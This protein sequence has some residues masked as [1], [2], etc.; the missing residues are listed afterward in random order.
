MNTNEHHVH[1]A[2]CKT[3]GRIAPWAE[4]ITI[5]LVAVFFAVSFFTGRVKPFLAPRYVWLPGMA[6]VALLGMAAARL[7][8]HFRGGVTCCESE[9]HSAWR[10][11]R[12]ACVII[13]I[14]PMVLGV[15][16]A[17]TRYSS[18]GMRKRRVSGPAR[19]V[20]LE[21][22]VKWVMGGTA[23][24]KTG[25]G[26]ASL[27]ENP[28]VLDVLTAAGEGDA[29]ALEGTFVTVIGQ[30]DLPDGAR[31][32][33]FDI[34]RLVV[35]CCI[36]DATAVA[37]EVARRPTVDLEAGGWVRVEGIIK[38]DSKIDPSIPVIHATVTTNVPE[39]SEPYL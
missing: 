23:A 33:R 12:S 38:F 29:K 27:P 11:P 4:I 25:S 8:A 21:Q 19:D 31:S 20:P 5:L 36:A 13:L 37:V 34:Y 39:P 7:R 22:A 10:V 15:I 3:G 1:G 35:T 28:T 18:E 32:E 24:G 26:G 9:E 16:V 30:C 2:S 6:A 14:L 17:P